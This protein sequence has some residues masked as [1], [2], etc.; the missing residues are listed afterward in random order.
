MGHMELLQVTTSSE[1]I[2]F[3]CGDDDLDDFVMNDSRQY[4]QSLLAET[5]LLKSDDDA[6]AYFTLLNDKISAESF[7]DRA[8]FNRFRK[9]LFVNSKRLRAYPSIKIGRLAVQKGHARKGYGSNLLDLIKILIMSNRYSGCR[10]MTVDAYKDAV[11]FYEKNGFVRI[12]ENAADKD[13]CLMVY[14]LL[15]VAVKS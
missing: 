8:S 9:R 15:T 4:H 13:T 6:L 11:P 5:F 2:V 10:F 7:D 1:P 14:D 3:T 12:G